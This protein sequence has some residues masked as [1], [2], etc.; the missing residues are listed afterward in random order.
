MVLKKPDD[1]S[2]SAVF[3][4]VH[5]ARLRIE[6]SMHPLS[7]RRIPASLLPGPGSC[8]R[9]GAIRGTPVAQ[10][11]YMRRP[12]PQQHRSQRSRFFEVL[13]QELPSQ[14]WI[15][16]L[17]SAAP[18]SLCQ[19]PI[20]Q[21]RFLRTCGLRRRVLGLPACK[22]TLHG[23]PPRETKMRKISMKLLLWRRR[24]EQIRGVCTWQL[25]FAATTPLI[26]NDSAQT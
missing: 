10:R 2:L 5:A 8:L 6:I 12:K 14:T 1:S 11:L 25:G 4:L 13:I 16:L 18:R 23:C 20:C 15:D 17:G 9:S 19:Q 26:H 21:T 24:Q 22:I 3:A 7:K